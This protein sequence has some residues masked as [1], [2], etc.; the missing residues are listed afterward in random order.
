VTR[1]TAVVVSVVL[2]GVLALVVPTGVATA[3]GNSSGKDIVSTTEDYVETFYPLWFTHFQFQVAPPNKFIGPDKISPLYQGVVAINDDTLYAS[4]PIDLSGGAV[5][6][7]VPA[8]PPAGYSVLLLDPYGNTY[9][10]PIPSRP[11]GDTTPQ[12]VYRLVGPDDTSGDVPGY[13][14][15]RLP[16]N[17]MIL[18]FRADKF[19]KGMDET[20]GATAFRAHLAINDVVTDIRS[21]ALFALPVKTIADT[22]IRVLPVT[23]LKQ[24]QVA[25]H[26]TKS[27]P[28]LSPQYQQLSDDF[29]ALFGDGSNLGPAQRVQFSKGARSAHTAILNNYLDNVGRTNWIHFTNIGQW[30]DAVVDRSSITEF[31]QFCN[32]ISTAAYYHAFRDGSGAPLDGSN[33]NGYVMTFKPGN[34]ADGG[35]PDATRFWS[36]TAY[37]PNAIELIPN[38]SNKYLVASYTHGLVKNRDGSISIYLSKTKPA[39]VPEANW[40]PVSTRNFNVMLRVYGVVPDSSVATNTYV[41]PPIERR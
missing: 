40:L 21:V 31:C 9:P 10:S 39:G 24:L 29:D 33:P 41:P 15:A 30:G 18:I 2:A 6:V 32:D 25:V 27:T 5:K 3:S 7:T 8:T 11:A 14:T 28:P 34:V 26:D 16:L 19:T 23:F 37:T 13:T 1:L 36:V 38:P 22:L 17:F 4:S 20:A 35:A 12:L